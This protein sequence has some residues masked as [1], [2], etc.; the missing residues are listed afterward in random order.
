MSNPWINVLELFEEDR[1]RFNETKDC[2]VVAFAVALNTTYE[3]AHAHMRI[4]CKRLHRRG[5]YMS[6][7]PN[8]GLNNTKHRIGP[9]TRKNK[10]TVAK[11]LKAHPQGRYYCLSRS[12][13]FAIIDGVLWDHTYRPRLEIVHAV[14]IY[15][16]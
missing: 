11:F 8:I 9:Y 3:K 16:D 7:Y 6:E 1:K 12:H 13:A 10:T 14:R 5:V 4:K 2:T 15:L